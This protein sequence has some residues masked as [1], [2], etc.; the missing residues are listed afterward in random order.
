MSGSAVRQKSS[1]C[2]V[3]RRTGSCIVVLALPLLL[4]SCVTVGI[5]KPKYEVIEKEGKFEIRQYQGQIV[6]ETIVESDFDNA[7]MQNPER[8]QNMILTRSPLRLKKTNKCPD[9]GSWPM[10]SLVIIANPSKL[11]RISVGWVET[12]IR[13]VGG[14]VSIRSPLLQSDA[15]VHLNRNCGQLGLLGLG[16]VRP[17]RTRCRPPV[18][19]KRRVLPRIALNWLGHSVAVS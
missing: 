4:C 15:S 8:S 6:A 14:Q 1:C 3:V 7:G 18:Q 2:A 9:R 11:R 17:H 13:T 16:I 19:E 10:F 5:E 12:N